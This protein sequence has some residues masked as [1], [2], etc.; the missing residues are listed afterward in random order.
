MVVG[1]RSNDEGGVDGTFVVA[2]QF[3]QIRLVGG[4]GQ[5][6][7]FEKGGG[8]F[9]GLGRRLTHHADLGGVLHFD[10]V[11][12]VMTGHAATTNHYGTYG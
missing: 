8:I 7:F 9:V 12:N 10:H 5:A 1:V 6:G 11:A 4:D 2:E 3:G